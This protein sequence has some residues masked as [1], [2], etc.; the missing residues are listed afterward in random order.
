MIS[1][2][3]WKCLRNALVQSSF[4]STST[5]NCTIPDRRCLGCACVRL[6]GASEYSDVWDVIF[7]WSLLAV[8]YSH[9]L[10][11]I[12]SVLLSVFFF[13]SPMFQCWVSVW[14]K[15]VR[16]LRS[17]WVHHGAQSRCRQ[18]AGT[19]SQ[20]GLGAGKPFWKL[21]QVFRRDLDFW[22]PCGLNNRFWTS[23]S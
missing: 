8:I 16:G 11:L 20:T 14:W 12:W 19:Q 7:S 18:D 10:S 23:G 6:R 2:V 3:Y 21:A 5:Q 17:G 9:D 22:G 13:F 4:G 1:L 15:L